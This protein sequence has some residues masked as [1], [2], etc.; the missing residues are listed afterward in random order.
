VP[1]DLHPFGTGF[2]T[3]ETTPEL[4]P[5]ILFPPLVTEELI[6]STLQEEGES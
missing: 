3:D 4:V 5:S 2:A 6:S 1:P